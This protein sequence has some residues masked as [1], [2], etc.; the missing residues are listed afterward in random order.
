MNGHSLVKMA[1]IFDRI[2]F[3]IIDGE[4]RLVEAMR[5][6]GLLNVLRK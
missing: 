3:I 4:S 6:L 5:E 2:S 1:H